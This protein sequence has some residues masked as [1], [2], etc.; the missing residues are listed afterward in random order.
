MI[1][2][3]IENMS[4]IK[5]IYIWSVCLEPL[6]FFIFMSLA[7]SNLGL[8]RVL[9][10][11]VLFSLPIKLIS[12]RFKVKSVIIFSPMYRYSSYLIIFSVFAWVGGLI[13]GAYTLPLLSIEDTMMI[14]IYRPAV[15]YII[16]IYYFFY[17]VI[18]A[19]YMLNDTIAVDYFLKIFSMLFYFSLIIGLSDL[20]L[21][22][23]IDGYGGLGRQLKSMISVG[24]RF[25]GIA[26]E[27]RDAFVYLILG[28]G[29]LY[30]KDIWRDEQKLT[31]KR[32]L[33]IFVAI[34]LTQSASGLIGLVFSS[35]LLLMYSFSKITFNKK[36]LALLMIFLLN[37]IVILSV[38]YSPRV[39]LYYEA[40]LILYD[41]LLNGYEVESVLQ[42]AMNNIYPIWH[43]WLELLD[44][45][46]LPL[47]FGTGLGSSSVVNNIYLDVNEVTN[48]NANI[49]RMFYDVGI[50]GVILLIKSFIYPINKLLIDKDIQLKFLVCMIFVLG[51]YLAHRHVAPFLLLG[52]IVAVFENKFRASIHKA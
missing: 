18:L 44:F 22:S 36:L 3:I 49:V 41:T 13:S 20:I 2:Y 26:G 25:H 15:E 5:K 16:A 28:I 35:A 50:I 39:L 51:A 29:V 45:N 31:K 30:L 43:R 47:F 19:R 12:N 8:G 4:F 10:I 7:S 9:Q 34:I 23:V 14:S 6:Y 42:Y 17:F 37:V 40:F 1:K 46:V 11:I 32:L 24:F 21:M 38:S 48:P 27:P 33:V 52:L